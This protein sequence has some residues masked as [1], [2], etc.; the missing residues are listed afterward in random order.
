M[1]DVKK[2]ALETFADPQRLRK[3]YVDDTFVIKNESC[4][5]FSPM[6]THVHRQ[7]HPTHYETRER[8]SN[9]GHIDQTLIKS[10]LSVYRKPTHLDRYSTSIVNQNTLYNKN[11]RWLTLF[12]NE[13]KNFPPQP[14]TW[15]AKWSMLNGLSCWIA[16]RNGWS[17]T[18]RSNTT[19]FLR[20]YLK[21]FYRIQLYWES[22]SN[23]FW[24][25]IVNKL[26]SSL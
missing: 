23:E 1:E 22:L 13:L 14:R 17:K 8:S 12:S 18:K 10:P 11:N 7:L 20:L 5:S 2:H 3:R 24:R 25:N 15:T 21:L 16:T 4:S 9:F 19:D 6:C 26:S